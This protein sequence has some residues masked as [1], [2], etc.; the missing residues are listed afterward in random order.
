M[1]NLI[2]MRMTVANP[3]IVGWVGQL[4]GEG[5][6]IAYNWVHDNRSHGPGIYLDNYCQNFVVDH[7]VIWNCGAGIRVNGPAKGHRL[8]NNTLFNCRDIGTRLYNQWPNHTPG[9][10]TAGGYGKST[11]IPKSTIYF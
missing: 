1:L 8:Y 11:D 3:I 6:R 5:T 7:N 9:Y 2:P 4:L 10:W